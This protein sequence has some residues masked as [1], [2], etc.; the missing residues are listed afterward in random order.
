MDDGLQNPTLAKD[1]TLAVVDGRRGL[2]NGRVMPAGPLRASLDMQLELTDGVVV[3]EPALAPGEV[4]DWL[5][6]RFR[7]TRP[8]RQHHTGVR[9]RLAKRTQGPGLGRH[10][11]AGALFPSCADWAR[12]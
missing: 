10:R 8:A 12:T 11:R 1:L 4:A 7:R 2:G 5:R 6:Q 9:A 3:S